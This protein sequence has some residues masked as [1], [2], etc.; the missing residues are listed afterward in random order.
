M[1]D[2]IW[3]LIGESDLN[4][5]HK[6]QKKTVSVV[7]NTTTSSSV[8]TYKIESSGEAPVLELWRVWNSSLL[9]LLPG[10]LLSVVLVRVL[11]RGQIDV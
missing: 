11:S 10:P 4:Y 5:S 3:G 7:F 9:L 6:S 8:N 1:S 2:F